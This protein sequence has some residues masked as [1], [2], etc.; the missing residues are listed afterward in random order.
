MPLPDIVRRSGRKLEDAQLHSYCS[1]A[2]NHNF[3]WHCMVPVKIEPSA[4]L[5]DC[6][7]V[8]FNGFHK[9]KQRVRSLTASA[10]FSLLH[11]IGS[12]AFEALKLTL[13]I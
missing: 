4:H 1:Q 10:P 8:H 5:M 6:F 13:F 11:F 3:M 2:W 9:F 7:R 12:L